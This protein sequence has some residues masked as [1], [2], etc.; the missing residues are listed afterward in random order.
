MI[1]LEQI[2][3][4]IEVLFWLG[5]LYIVVAIA[6]H[7]VRLGY[8]ATG[9]LLV[10]W[11]LFLLH[12]ADISGRVYLHGYTIPLG[13]YI[14]AISYLEWQYGHKTLAMWLDYAAVFMMMGT[15]FW[16]TLQF[17]WLYAM[18]LGSEGLAALWWGSARRLRRF[19]YAG[20]VGVILATLGQL[21]N[22]LWS[23]NQWI[24]FGLIGLSLVIIAVIVERKL[25]DIK[26]LREVFETWD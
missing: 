22:A 18:L 9:M 6:R 12:I 2:W 1:S 8:V 13:L 19:L 4:I 5:L 26:T 25:E 10:A 11:L 7:S 21:I 20:M 14:L 23:V 3:V 16:Q 15:L 24:V 17:G